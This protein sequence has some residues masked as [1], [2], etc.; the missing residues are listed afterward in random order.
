MNKSELLEK[1]APHYEEEEILEIAHAIDVATLAHNG[2]KRKSGEPYIIHPLSVAGTLI[3]WGMD[4]DSVL[5]GVLHDTV[6]DTDVI[7][8]QLETL[9]GKNVAFLVDGVTKVSQARA[10]MQDLSTYLPQTKDNLSKLLIAV[11]QD[12]RV[13]IIKLADR[14][15]NLQT[16]Q[17]MPHD[18]QVKIARE[19]LEVFGPMADR[20]GMGRVRMEIEELAFS[21]LDPVEFKKMRNLIRKRLG[22]STRKLGII[23]E[24]VSKA[25]HREKVEFEIN[26]RVK[27]IYSLHKKLAK[28]QG[29]ID[30]IYDLMA[31][32]IIVETKEEC[33]RV[34]GVLH[35]LYQPMITRIKDYIAIPKPNGYQ[36]LH[37]TV[38]TPTKQIIEFQIRT[39]DM[40][41]F[42]ERGLAAS[43]HYHE[44]KSSKDYIQAKKSTILPTHMQWINQLQEVANKLR[45]GETITTD[46]LNVD[47]F[48][49]RIFV[50]SPKGDIY[51]LP[52][53]A[54]P[55]DF[56][57]LVHSDI[58]KHANGFRVNGMIRPFNEPL[59]NGD[60]VE[61]MT[62]KSS[63]P[64][65]AWL[66]QVTT[67]HARNKL[68]AQ[69]RQLGVIAG[70]SHAAAIIRNK[71]MH[72]KEK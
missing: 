6:E 3:D 69:L 23:R 70:I 2:Q 30:D 52:E 72:K 44:Q 50:Y 56:A 32:R 21:Y 45:S 22:K 36:S 28:V 46:Q 67:T 11:G 8:N 63:A 65:Q 71:T 53:G 59:Q 34:L 25:L 29:N 5:A 10:G 47:L 18:K 20:L 41:E 1:A 33:Y 26:G 15:H 24:E 61:V 17:H 43:F 14:L 38:I 27:S 35:A 9:F 42:A 68:R 60:I 12:V 7:L 64:K 62:K 37:T 58:G 55:L 66:D 48:G 4:I 19:S 39:Y 57:Y 51:N 54:L 40:H 13:I 16:L 49:D 31:L